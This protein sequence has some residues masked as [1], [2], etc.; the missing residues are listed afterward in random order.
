MGGFRSCRNFSR[1]GTCEKAG[2]K[3]LMSKPKTKSWNYGKFSFT[4]RSPSRDPANYERTIRVINHHLGLYWHQFIG[5]AATMLEN[6][7]DYYLFAL[8]DAIGITESD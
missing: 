6:M 1:L 5:Y 2:A 8:A 4:S 7:I 3:K